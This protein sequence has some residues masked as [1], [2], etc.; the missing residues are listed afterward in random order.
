MWQWVQSKLLLISG[1]IVGLLLIALVS[2]SLYADVQAT[3][4]EKLTSDLTRVTEQRDE[5]QRSLER[6]SKSSVVTEEVVTEN[7]K[8]K[9][10]N[11]TKAK[12]VRAKVVEAEKKKLDGQISDAQFDNELI[13][14]MWDAYCNTVQANSDCTSRQSTK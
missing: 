7:S 8:A 9:V 1:V 2:V 10:E 14:G 6:V 11:S 3:K 12:E 13:D 5:A 4:V